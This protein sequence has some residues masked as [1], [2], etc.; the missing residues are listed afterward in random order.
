MSDT[1]R[2]DD[3]MVTSVIA[4]I[5]PLLPLAVLTAFGERRRAG[6]LASAVVAGLFFPVTWIVWYLRDEHP[7][8]RE[9]HGA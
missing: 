6:G 5:A 4:W 7:Y 3:S 9:P 8:R 1:E 2:M